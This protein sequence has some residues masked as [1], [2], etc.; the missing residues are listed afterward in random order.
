MYPA[1]LTFD[2]LCSWVDSS[3]DLSVSF[4]ADGGGDSP[5]HMSLGVIIVLPILGTFW[6]DLLVGKIKETDIDAQVMLAKSTEEA[7]VGLHVFHIERSEAYRS[8]VFGKSFTKLA[9]EEI[10]GVAGKRPWKISGYSGK[11]LRDLTNAY[12]EELCFV[13]LTSADNVSQHLQLRQ[14]EKRLSERLDLSPQGTVKPLSPLGVA[15]AANRDQK[16]YARFQDKL[17]WMTDYRMTLLYWPNWI[18]S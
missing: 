12:V 3:P 15:M 9:L 4:L 16:W 17:L 7:D 10:Q 1:P 11:R 18:W 8:E 14:P 5:V 13:K 2:R 6:K